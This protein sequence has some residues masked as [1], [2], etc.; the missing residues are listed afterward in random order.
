MRNHTAQHPQSWCSDCSSPDRECGGE[1]TDYHTFAS[2][3]G[4]GADHDFGLVVPTVSVGAY[5]CEWEGDTE[6]AA[7]PS[8]VITTTNPYS[9]VSTTVTLGY[10]TAVGLLL[11]L[12]EAVAHLRRLMDGTTAPHLIC[13][14]GDQ[15]EVDH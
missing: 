2:R 3:Y 9:S 10:P 8:L 12:D 5:W 1:H 4:A 7:L 13:R 14:C 6:E 11:H 15:P